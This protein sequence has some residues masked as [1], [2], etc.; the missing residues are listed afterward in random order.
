MDIPWVLPTNPMW[1]LG[2]FAIGIAGFVAQVLLTMG[3]QKES[4]GRASMGLYSQVGNSC[5]GLVGRQ[6]I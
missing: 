2:L 5:E 6:F 1:V 3:L 4:A